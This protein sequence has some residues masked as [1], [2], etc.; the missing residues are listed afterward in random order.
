[1][2]STNDNG[3][4]EKS[5]DNVE[6][7]LCDQEGIGKAVVVICGACH[8]L[9]CVIYE[10]IDGSCEVDDEMLARDMS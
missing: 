5:L 6:G 9:L 8:A 4:S 10:S 1:M 7:G 2:G 3:V